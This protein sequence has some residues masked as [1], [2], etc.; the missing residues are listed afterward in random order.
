[1]DW[2]QL[3]N[4]ESQMAKGIV[5]RWF[6]AVLSLIPLTAKADGLTLAGMWSFQLDREDRG[7]AEQWFARDL[8][9]VIVLPGV[10]TAQGYGDPVSMQTKWTGNISKTWQSDP[11]YKQYQTPG[12]FKMPFWLQPDRHYVGAVWY[13]RQI[14]ITPEWQGKR[15]LLFLER[16][17]WKTTVWLDGQHIGS[18]D[19]LGT[20]HVY[21]LGANVTGGKHRLTIRVDNRMIADVGNNAHS[22][23]DH[24]QGNW[25]GIVGRMELRATDPVWIDDVRVYPDIKGKT[26]KVNVSLGN[27]TGASGTGTLTI[28]VAGP[29]WRGRPAL[30]SRGHPGLASDTP[31]GS[32][33]QGQDALATAGVPNAG[34]PL[35]VPVSWTAQGGSAECT[36]PMGSDCQLWDEFRPN[37]YTMTVELKGSNCQDQTSV[38][39]GMR[40]VGVQGT[41]I[42]INGKPIFL[43]GTLECCI[44]PLSGHPPTDVD[45]WKRI[46]RIC[47]AHGLNHIRFHSWCPPE[48]AFIAADELG[49]YYH[50]ECSAWA[51]VGDGGPFDKWLYQESEAMVKAYGNHPSFTFMA[52]GNEPGGKNQNR[53]LGDFVSY[54]KQRD[55]RRLYTSGA[56]W[57]ML[58]ENDYYSTPAP[59]IQQWGQGV[60]SRV[61]GKPPE[62]MTDYRDFVEQH[63]NAP[64]VSHE[65]GQWCVYPNLDEM[66]KYT[67]LLKARNFEIFQDQLDRNGMLHQA[68][69]F[70]MASGKLQALLYKEDIESAL[71][72]PGF[73][74]FQLLDLHDFPGQGTA[75]VGVL[76][77]FWD[78]KGYITAR[79]YRRFAGPMVPLARLERRIFESGDVVQARIEL[80]QF[81]PVDLENVTP[82]W[83][84]RSSAG[85]VAEGSLPKQTIKAGTLS[86][87]GE[88]RAKLP[89][90]EKAQ[91]LN[92]EV[93]IH[94]TEAANDWDLWVF[95]KS[96][97][98]RGRPALASRGHLGLA[99]SSPD[100]TT[101]S[102][103]QGQ[104]ALATPADD[105]LVTRELNEAAIDRLNRGGKV[106]F[107]PAAQTIRNDER[108]PITMGFSSIFWNTVWTDWQ[109]P[110]T[111]GIL[112]DP[113]H[114]ALEQFPTEYHS[115]WQWWELI[116]GAAPFILTSHRNLQ[117]VVQVVDDWV[118]ARKLALV[119]EAR[120]G[121]GRLLA[122]SCD[123]V[124]DLDKRPVA[125][126]MR[127]SLLAYMADGRFDPKY[128]M[129][130]EQLSDLLK[131]PS[132][133]QKLGA[134]AAAS[135]YHPAHSPDLAIDGDPA[136]IW[137]T[138]WEP[139]AKP[140]HELI[141]DLKE[142]VR[143]RGLTY[144]P[145]Q[146]MTNGRIARYEVYLSTDGKE[147]GRPAATGTWPNDAKLK[148]VRFENPQT[149]RYVKLV[150][151]SEVRGQPFA[152]AAEVDI[153][154]E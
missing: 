71:R 47:K 114:P 149:A 59:R 127:H 10:L 31:V 51:T 152:S 94:G 109:P 28:H 23:S 49:F 90:S 132:L 11:Y 43:R 37:L 25:N 48:A 124:S 22:V 4:K 113:N 32:E 120:V 52:Y 7:E 138:N 15:V 62:T 110:H 72:T 70:L 111:L 123:L 134:T 63:K 96:V 53:F 1:V 89:N 66:T 69:A 74:G 64:V 86:T 84:I 76:D 40:E 131:Q 6:L 79:Q 116:H 133:L 147:W 115:N 3:R 121:S 139:M 68:H 129:T 36:Y 144:L 46:I 88:I 81:G 125:R 104:D 61:N 16:P 142:S 97:S 101:G 146:D 99:S 117:P 148:T 102:A 105:I 145:R 77:P 2:N 73:G 103:T 57:P 82:L 39:F 12:N 151:H 140:P 85:I 42:A 8:S 65:I 128:N 41:R 18:K 92:L 118:T 54:W 38:K 29:S 58:P 95:P 91:K 80:A 108:H 83:A 56:G 107:L 143:L 130:V 26:V 87:L 150:A 122:C 13:Q 135:N 126:Q 24:T 9:G 50:V 78:S 34:Q 141:L 55:S 154:V 67:G 19:S 119:F 45:S 136:T 14:E 35:S 27:S 93:T 5:P 75:L 112:C 33:M 20:P 21:E 30:A 100:A 98:W 60:H 137:H 44:F 106:L 153:L 17:H